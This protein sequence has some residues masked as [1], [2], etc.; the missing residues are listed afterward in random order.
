MGERREARGVRRE[1]ARRLSA[2]RGA[3]GG[4]GA[5]KK[6]FEVSSNSV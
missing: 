5:K 6:S 1:A 3:A 4:S 2:E